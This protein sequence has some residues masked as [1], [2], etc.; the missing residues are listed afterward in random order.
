[1]HLQ[2]KRFYKLL[3]ETYA[4]AGTSE[5][6]VSFDSVAQIYDKTRGPP[7]RIMKQLGDTLIGELQGHRMVLDVGVGT[8]R[9]AKPLQASGFEVVG[10]DISG[11]MLGKAVEKGVDNLFRGDACFLPF[12]DNS[13]DVAVCVHI[14]HLICEWKTALQEICRV[15]R[16]IMV[17]THYVCRDPL[18]EAY[19]RLLKG[20]GYESR[21]LGKGEWE[22]KDLVKPLKTVVVAS[23]GASANRRLAFLG[24]RVY[25][26]Q[27]DIPEDVNRK[28]VNELKR[29]FAGK[30][31]PQELQ[32]LIWAMKDLEAFSLRSGNNLVQRRD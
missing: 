20:Y 28:V 24:Q 9:F 16:G 32:I 1:V 12:V 6:R 13:F 27:W 10:V 21:R 23:Y 19:T 14:L 2:A 25:S 15:T 26:S 18:R 7:G 11:K 17:S 29:R 22:L 5:M 4:R 3:S 30:V 31:F 8:G